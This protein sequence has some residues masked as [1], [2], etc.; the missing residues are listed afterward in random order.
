[1][2]DTK[3]SEQIEQENYDKMLGAMAE[4][5]MH[6]DAEQYDGDENNDKTIDDY[7]LDIESAM[8]K[9]NSSDENVGGEAT[10]N[11]DE[12]TE[13]ELEALTAMEEY[14]KFHGKEKYEY[15]V[16]GALLHC[17]CGSHH[18]R[19]NLPKCHGVY[20]LG[21]PL[22]RSDDCKAGLEGSNINI[23]SFGICNAPGSGKI[24]MGNI[25]LEPELLGKDG[26]P[27]H[28]KTYGDI[29]TGNRCMAS[30][31]SGTWENTHY[32]TQITDEGKFA[33]TTNSFL[34]CEH[35]GVIRVITSGQE[36]TIQEEDIS[37]MSQYEL[38]EAAQAEIE[39]IIASDA[40]WQI[41]ADQIRQVYEKSLYNYNDEVKAAFDAYG[42]AKGSGDQKKLTEA[43]SVLNKL[44]QE[45]PIDIKAVGR[46]LSDN[47][48]RVV[49]QNNNNLGE[50]LLNF[51]D[52]VD[53]G[54]P[55]DL[56]SHALSSA[57]GSSSETHDFSIWARGWNGNESPDYLGNY[58]YGYLSAGYF[59]DLDFDNAVIPVAGSVGVGSTLNTGSPTVGLVNATAT[60]VT[61]KV[62]IDTL[63]TMN[64]D[65]TD[66]E[67]MCLVA[68]GVA[69]G[70]SDKDPLKFADSFL[71]GNW[72][73]N[74]KDSEYCSDGFNDYYQA[75]GLEK[76]EIIEDERKIW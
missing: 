40:D 65:K 3:S 8:A 63:R 50:E 30:F 70:I 56:K 45:T 76:S 66:A 54:M 28:G 47:I 11:P 67:I 59:R 37:D 31:S 44:L 27:I 41:K 38:P 49:P 19:L 43:E 24:N 57:I 25:S 72:G 75:N 39:A 15:V 5:A 35:G 16:R 33:L 2:S 6:K 1:M 62:A 29:I 23:T 48:L 52:L 22:L 58:T 71:S 34:K 42:V 9:L 14:S 53:T 21:N 74:E 18:R 12:F 32:K 68:A 20:R 13:D 46:S 51:M 61:I 7:K 69:Q 64:P 36:I 60:G 26:L 17:S 55:M 4:Y 73:D 10:I